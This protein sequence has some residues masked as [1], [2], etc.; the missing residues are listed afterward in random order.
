MCM[1]PEQ[2]T[3]LIFVYVRAKRKYTC[4]NQQTLATWQKKKKET[5]ES[6]KDLA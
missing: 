2:S 6:K 3:T 5:K 1:L 4:D